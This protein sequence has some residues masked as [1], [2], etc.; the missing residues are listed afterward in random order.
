MVAELDKLRART[1]LI[2]ILPATIIAALVFMATLS[3]GTFPGQSADLMVTYSGLM[4]YIAPAH[5]LWGA[6]AGFFSECGDNA[7]MVWRL[8]FLSLIYGI[9]SV[10][11]IGDIV[12]R[13]TF[14]LIDHEM[15]VPK[16]AAWA[17]ALGGAAAS[18]ALAFSVPFWISATRFQ[19]Q[20]F[21][22]MLLL[23]V[24]RILLAYFSTGFT[25][26]LFLFTL[27]Y[28]VA[29]IESLSLILFLPLFFVSVVI[30][31]SRNEK[32]GVGRLIGSLLFF[33]LGLGS[34]WLIA[35]TFSANNDLSIRGYGSIWGVVY[36]I[37]ADQVSALKTAFPRTGWLHLILFGVLPFAAV[38]AIAR[39]ALGDAREW[40]VMIMHAAISVAVVIVLGNS[41]LVSPWAIYRGTGVLPVIFY[42]ITAVVCGYLVTYW[43]MMVVNFNDITTDTEKTVSQKSSLL[44]ECLFGGIIAVMVPITATINSFEA[45]GKNGKF[46]DDCVRELIESLDGRR[47]ILSDGLFDSQIL[48]E[49]HTKGVDVKLL[50]LHNNENEIYLRYLGQLVRNDKDFEGINPIA[51][52]KSVSLGVLPFLQD[53]FDA[54]TNLIDRLA[55]VSSPD[56]IIAENRVVVPNKFFF[57]AGKKGGVKSED[58]LSEHR[59][60][61]ERKLKDLGKSRTGRDAI[62]AYR[63][64]IRRQVGFVANNAG[65]LL[66][67][68]GEDEEAYQ[69]YSYV[70]RLDSENVSALLNLLEIL[71]RKEAE[72]FHADQKEALEKSF[73]Q[74]IKELEGRKLPIWSLS[75]TFGYV[76]SPILFT[77]LGWAWAASGQPGIALAGIKRAADVAATPAS[78]M[79]VQEIRADLLLKQNDIDGSEE[80]YEEILKTDPANT[81]A[82]M[83]MA[84]VEVRKGSLDKAREWL[85]KAQENEA[86]KIDL[87]LESAMLDITTGNM[88]DARVKLTEVTDVYSKNLQA[89]A[90]LAIVTMQMKDFDDVEKRILPKMEFI[91]GTTDDYL[92]LIIRGQLMLSGRQ[93]LKGAR[94]VFERAAVL[95]PGIIPLMEQVLSL[96]RALVDKESAE[97]HARQLLRSSRDNPL[98]NYIMGSIVLERGILD[99]AEYY[100]RRSVSTKPT[101]EALNDLAELL[102][103]IG[104]LEEAENRIRTAISLT[105]DFYIV[106]DTLGGILY[107][108]GDL[109]GAE[110]AY[111]KAMELAGGEDVRININ[112]AKLLI[113][114]GDTVQARKLL[115][116]ANPKRSTL[117][118]N[119]QEEFE[120]LLKSLTPKR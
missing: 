71:H 104:N 49:A 4:P 120:S 74:M 69:T 67:D 64:M 98:A 34:V 31:M 109:S 14:A 85:A 7:G 82:L 53:W 87:A 20:G 15:T 16:R 108:K 106:W 37:I 95:R 77:Q 52:E 39:R 11:L 113:K 81:R 13:A 41:P 6:I 10:W 27:L 116:E 99:E 19:Y 93:N 12:S 33:C 18:L 55:V 63:K 114:K 1:S 101:P 46:A 76:R 45:S 115:M 94:D 40:G 79:R 110:E 43:Y 72:N 59:E 35:K 61:W 70:R 54:D 3:P 50:Q 17:S 100:L 107:E 38:V 42:A 25:L 2:T 68:L 21:D 103:M 78:R 111:L 89:W 102:R 90:M 88:A 73:N 48:I 9:V 117:P 58:F 65:V 83:N 28:G 112:Y 30:Y 80:I 118:D 57:V 47:W 29:V 86:N 105:P 8:N 97:E 96:D 75:R 51:L 84:R 32:L 5:S 44:F 62:G 24:T 119:M 23:I 60:F 91:A 22:L 66:E 26:V 36:S 56:L 92:T